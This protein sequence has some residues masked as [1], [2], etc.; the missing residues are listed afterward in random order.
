MRARWAKTVDS[1]DRLLEQGRQEQERLRQLSR[2]LTVEL[3]AK[4]E[5]S[6]FEIRKDMLLV[7]G[8]VLQIVARRQ[9]SSIDELAGDV[10]AGL[11]LAL[12]AGGADLLTTVPGGKVVAPG[13]IVRGGIDERVLLKPQ[14]KQEAG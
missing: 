13:V 11:T 12:R 7:V 9:A 5:E 6:R 4:R 2:D 8:E 10:E 14:I 3:K 1:Y